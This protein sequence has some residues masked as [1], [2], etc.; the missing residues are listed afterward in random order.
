M[1]LA[2]HSIGAKIFG[3]FA[4]MSAIIGLT[5]LPAMACSPRPAISR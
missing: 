5:G 1:H 2:K 4:A 3:A